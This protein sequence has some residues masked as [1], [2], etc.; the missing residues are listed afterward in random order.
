LEFIYKEETMTR[1]QRQAIDLLIQIHKP[2]PM[3][4]AL[5]IIGSLASGSE[6]KSSDIDLYLI[7]TD[8]AFKNIQQHRSYFYGSW[9]PQQFFGVGIDGKIVGIEFLREAVKR[10]SEPTRASFLN[11][12]TE[13]TKDPEIVELVRQIPTYPELEREPRCRAFFGMVK[14]FRYEGE[15]A[16]QSNN[17]FYFQSCVQNMVFFA[18]RLVLAHNRI[19]YP[20]RKSLFRVLEQAV[21]QPSDFMAQSINLLDY[22]DSVSLIDYYESIVQHYSCYEMDDDERIGILL[23]NEMNWFTGAPS[24]DEW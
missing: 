3:K 18:A 6:R 15:Q 16:F 24:F 10:G 21:D 5:I 9:D 23:E 12:Y 22:K 2:D 11:A 1:N 8:E 4:L 19:L 7:V 20:C 17:R 14:H 13:F